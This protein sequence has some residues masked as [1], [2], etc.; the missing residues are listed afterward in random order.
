ML[1]TDLL[2]DLGNQKQPM[3]DTWGAA[4]I[5]LALV[6]LTHT[7]FA[8][9]QRNILD[10]GHRMRHGFNTGSIHRA[11]FLDDV[12]KTIHL[13]QHAL[14][15][16]GLELQTGEIGNAG[17]I[18]RSQGHDVSSIETSCNPSLKRGLWLKFSQG[19]GYYPAFGLMLARQR[20][21]GKKIQF[22]PVNMVMPGRGARHTREDF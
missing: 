17:D 12:E 6:G 15:L 1:C 11:H 14:T 13:P 10:G 16:I 7:V 8:Q 21:F 2:D 9:A 4:L 18:S 20:V 5:G 19:M 3:L 22:N